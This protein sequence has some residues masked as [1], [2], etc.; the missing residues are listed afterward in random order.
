MLRLEPAG[1]QPPEAH[2]YAVG[3][4]HGFMQPPS[5]IASRCERA[6]SGLRSFRPIEIVRCGH[7][8]LRDRDAR[9]GDR[10]SGRADNGY[11]RGN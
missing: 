7:P 8:K 1:R 11:S 3:E 2:A 5:R 9:R 4:A 6:F 10:A